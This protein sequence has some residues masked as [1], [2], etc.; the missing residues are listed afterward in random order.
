MFEIVYDSAHLFG[1]VYASVQCVS[2]HSLSD[3]ERSLI[4]TAD[5][6]LDIYTANGATFTQHQVRLWSNDLQMSKS[7]INHIFY[8]Y[9]I[10]AIIRHSRIEDPVE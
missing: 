6:P 3:A 8:M 5:I 1:I 7:L 10:L 4:Q 9:R 2:Y